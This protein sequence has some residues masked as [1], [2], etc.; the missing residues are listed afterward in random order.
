M[1]PCPPAAS[2]GRLSIFAFP[3]FAVVLAAPPA[4]AQ[5]PGELVLDDI[6]VSATARPTDA[7]RVG[8]SVTVITAEDLRRTQ[9]RTLTEALAAVPG[10][11]IV[12]TGGPGGQ[13]S[14]FMRGTN[15]NHVKVLIDG[16]E[17]ND[18]STPNRAFDFGQL[19]T[20][21]D[22]ERI[23]VLRGP[24]SGL[25]GA[26]AFGGVISVTTRRGEG[27]PSVRAQV[28]GGS[29]GTFNQS[30]ALSGGDER[31]D[32]A[33]NVGHYRADHTPSVPDDLVA[34]GQKVA[35]NAYDNWSWSS[36]LGVALGDTLRID[37]TGRHIDARFEG[38]H[39]DW[40]V[41]T[42]H[43]S[44]QDYRQTFTRAQAT[45]DPLDGRFVQRF[46]AAYTRQDRAYRAPDGSGVLGAPSDSLGER[47][48]L[49]W[50]G[51]LVVGPDH[52]LVVGVQHDDERLETA[53]LTASNASTGAFAELQSAFGDRFFLTANL[54]YDRDES[55]G[56]HATWRIAPAYVVPG[57]GTRLKAS[58]GTAFKAP[59]LSELF[60]DYRPGFNFHG[61]PDLKPEENRGFDIGFEQPLW[62]GR[63]DI[64]ATY[65]HNDLTNLIV[66][67]A[68]TYFNVGKAVT[69]GFETFARVQ[70]TPELHLRADYTFTLAE[71]E[72]TGLELLR[73]PRH[74][75]S[76]AATWTP[77]EKLT[78]T[79]TA[80]YLS[81]WID[82]NRDFSVARMRADGA[83]IVNL[84]AE[85][86]ATEHVSVF[87][88]VD[89]L[90]DE[91]FENPVGFLTPGL[92]AFGGL[93]V[94]L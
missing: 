51:D 13:T 6:V 19:L 2:S 87:G 15:S 22:I 18:P 59:T 62:G 37:W 9:R 69:Q 31:F 73:R 4:A 35:T 82:G 3:L 72:D 32:Y 54:R 78:L 40:G 84:A 80:I 86:D 49:D 29:H 5:A 43:R 21:D 60:V 24:Q 17:V 79:G 94:R 53:S 44:R 7:A 93:R 26:N 76:L 66:G 91:D 70:A 28:E 23:E 88:R 57:T 33:F 39:D 55:F 41:P 67:G 85:Y 42:P 27:P 47:T 34:P 77:V 75:A 45:W 12:Q 16:I 65:F 38:V 11:N 25:Y 58:Y 90:F 1:T 14:V 52:T 89:N 61:N 92:S 68:E 48:R 46:G 71:D 64:G 10:L 81:G 74:K 20:L 8:S 56:G 50:R 30:A 63:A 36:R 83:V